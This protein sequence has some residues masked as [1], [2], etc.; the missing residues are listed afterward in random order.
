MIILKSLFFGS[1][2]QQLLLLYTLLIVQLNLAV[3]SIVIFL[4]VQLQIQQ[5]P[6]LT[7]LDLVVILDYILLELRVMEMK[8]YLHL[9]MEQ[10]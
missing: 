4:L 6:Q 10:L 8:L 5:M 2:V 1:V 9:V 3:Q 7:I